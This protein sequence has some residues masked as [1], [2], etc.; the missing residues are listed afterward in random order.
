MI[1]EL[2]ISTFEK[3]CRFEKNHFKIRG[4][5]PGKLPS[6]DI[7]GECSKGL[8]KFFPGFQDS[9]LLLVNV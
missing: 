9:C 6:S 8:G 2:V 3:C 4:K 1:K 5:I 7:S